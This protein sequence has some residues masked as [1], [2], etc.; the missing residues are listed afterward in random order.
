MQQHGFGVY[1]IE[2]PSEGEMVINKALEVGYRSF[3]TAQLYKNEGLLGR[4]LKK[5]PIDR[6]E[7][8]ITT[9]INNDKQGV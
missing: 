7:L 3:D 9:T 2:D 6:S 1:L 5:S 4:I 8:F